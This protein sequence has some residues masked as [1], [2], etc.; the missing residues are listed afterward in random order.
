MTRFTRIFLSFIFLFLFTLSTAGASQPIVQ[1][2]DDPYTL[3]Y[4]KWD[5]G[6]YIGA[7]E[8]FLAILDSEDAELYF[9]QIAT[10]TGELY[11]V[12]ELS[13]DGRSPVFSPDN[14]HFAWQETRDGITR[15]LISR[16]TGNGTEHLHTLDGTGLV[17]SPD[18]RHAVFFR[19]TITPR[20]EQLGQEINE[21]RENRDRD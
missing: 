21:A 3:A 13:E 5:A 18:G 4:L 1:S 12:N 6:D 2:S 20:M 16:I 11:V 19:T 15:T 9:D 14:R 8:D 10:L 7:L 17:F